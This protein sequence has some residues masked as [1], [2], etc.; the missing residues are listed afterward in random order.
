MA[1]STKKYIELKA[2][3]IKE[4]GD[5]IVDFVDMAD[6]WKRANIYMRKQ[7]NLLLDG[8]VNDVV[9]KVTDYDSNGDAIYT[10]IFSHQKLTRDRWFV[11]LLME[12]LN[13][14]KSELDEYIKRSK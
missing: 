7:N 5:I 9:K 14:S 2:L 3:I 10:L 6:I 8:Y 12:Q 11:V 4:V 1:L 13:M